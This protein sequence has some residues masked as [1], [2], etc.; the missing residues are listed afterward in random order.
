MKKK[1]ILSLYEETRSTEITDQR[2]VH[3]IQSCPY[4]HQISSDN[5]YIAKNWMKFVSSMTTFIPVENPPRVSAKCFLILLHKYESYLIHT[6]VFKGFPSWGII[7]WIFSLPVGS[8]SILLSDVNPLELPVFLC[9]QLGIVVPLI[10]C[11]VIIVSCIDAV[12]GGDLYSAVAF[13]FTYVFTFS[14]CA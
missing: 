4:T 5:V 9:P 10:S 12:T 8:T 7:N 2:T 14:L 3:L 1:Y 13:Y 6:F 11:K